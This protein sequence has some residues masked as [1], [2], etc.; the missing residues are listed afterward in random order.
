MKKSELIEMI[1]EIVATNSVM[2]A[3]SRPPEKY[4]GEEWDART[5]STFASIALILPAAIV[6]A[7]LA[8]SVW[9]PIKHKYNKF[10]TDI[11]NRKLGETVSVEE[12]AKEVEEA[13]KIL[14]RGMKYDLQKMFN[15]AKNAE[16]PKELGERIT[17]IRNHIKKY[18]NPT[19]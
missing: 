4:P 5:P 3:T 9:R 16:T 18:K 10:V 6:L 2:R 14:S 7:A 1:R 12:L 11:K 15:D 19:E 17:K 13:S 8:P